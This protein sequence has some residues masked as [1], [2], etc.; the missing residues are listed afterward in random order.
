MDEAILTAKRESKH[1]DF[2]R[3]FD[4]DSAAAWCEVL[5]DIA[6]FANSGGGNI[7]VGVNNDGSPSEDASVVKVLA[8]DPATVTDKV[9]SYTGTQFDGVAIVE[10]T[11][12]GVAVAVLSVNAAQSP[13]VFTRPGTYALAD[14]KQKTAFSQGTLYVRH[15]A[16]SEPANSDDVGKI[17]ERRLQEARKEWMAGVRKVVA[18]PSGSTVTVMP[19][20]VRQSNSPESMPIRITNNA[21][22]PEYRL[23]DPDVT[24]P[25]R[26]KELIAE[27]NKKLP[28]GKKI[29]QHHIR[30]LRS[31]YDIDSNP[32]FFHKSKFASPQY[33]AALYE[34]PLGQYTRDGQFFVKTADEFRRRT[35]AG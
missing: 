30:A 10:A 1:L 6:A 21:A 25:W 16:K 11:K 19:S 24:H 3:S 12:G 27:I 23:V 34:W 14:G 4:S 35:A 33:S 18:A 32:E 26:G 8:L 7:L 2:K 22:A 20:G 28:D 17:I 9:A 15:G 13:L 29:N 5:K 31:L